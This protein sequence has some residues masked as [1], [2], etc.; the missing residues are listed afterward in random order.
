LGRSATKIWQLA[1]ALAPRNTDI[2]PS[3]L[4]MKQSL[5]PHAHFK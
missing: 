5:T 1:Q 4:L 2:S 3:D